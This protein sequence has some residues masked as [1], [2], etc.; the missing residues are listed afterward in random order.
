MRLR[1]ALLLAALS[2]FIALSYE[3]VW[4][5]VFSMMSWG[6]ASAFGALLGA[7][8]TGIAFGALYARRFCRAEGHRE[9]R[10]LAWFILFANLVGFL[11]VP[12]AA[13][14]ARV[15]PVAWSL[16]LFALGAGLLGTTFPLIA[17][18]G[19]D[20]D[21]HAG[22]GV[23]YLYGANIVGSTAGSLL[24]GFVLLELPIA[25]VS[26]ILALA[27]LA[28]F[29]GIARRWRET[30]VGALF[31]VG[32]S[33]FLFDGLYEKM[34]FKE[35]YEP[36]QRFALVIE[37][38][39]GVV[40][41]TEDGTVY[42]G[43]VYDG[44][45]NVDPKDDINGIFRAY[46]PF[47]FR[48]P[49]KTA[50]VIGMGSGSWTQVLASH[51]DVERVL[52]IEIGEDYL[53]VVRHSPVVRSILDNPKVEIVIDD[54]R[55]WMLRHDETFDWIVQNTTYHFR[56]HATNL[57]SREYLELS[58]KHLNEG[59]LILYNTTRSKDAQRT[60]AMVFP[61]C[62]LVDNA[63]IVSDKPLIRDRARHREVLANY[64]ID[65]KRL[66]D[67]PKDRETLEALVADERWYSAEQVLARTEGAVVITD[68]NMASEWAFLR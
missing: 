36:G 3:I 53:D 59:G 31:V 51:P 55:R 14:L 45:F 66:F 41:V 42:G 9:L 56:A 16:V 7:Y 44:K 57:L 25:R 24:T 60:G 32:C 61:Y 22:A 1:L 2:G 29:F 50:L 12:L 38:K 20:P 49:P 23:S 52:V 11:L 63:M 39:S 64:V 5:R 65:G 8:L 46:A 28:V 19:V 62:W 4:I 43:G 54:G 58:R 21:E 47:A 27:G 34:Q 30:L 17:H 37:G 26:V 40:T 6:K 48:A 13:E 35:E 68:D 15:A 10:A 67:L 18:F 33:L